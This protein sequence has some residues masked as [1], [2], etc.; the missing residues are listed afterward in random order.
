MIGDF[1][2]GGNFPLQFQQRSLESNRLVQD[3]ILSQEENKPKN[4]LKTSQGI[5][6]TEKGVLIVAGARR[7]GKRKVKIRAR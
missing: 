6:A 7:T 1:Q 5:S 4:S 2:N 3:G